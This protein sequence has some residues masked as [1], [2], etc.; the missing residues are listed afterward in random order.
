MYI[1]INL[2]MLTEGIRDFEIEKFYTARIGNS[3]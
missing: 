3:H 1:Y 2:I